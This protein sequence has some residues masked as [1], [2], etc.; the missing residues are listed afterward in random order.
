MKILFVPSD[1]NS[2]SGAFRSM[3]KLN[4][5]LN[6]EHGIE[7]LV[8]LPNKTGD[9]VKLLEKYGVKYCFIES[10]NWIVKSDKELTVDDEYYMNINKHKNLQAIKA[11]VSLIK[12]EKIDIIHINT[13]YSY[14]AAIAG[15]ITK[16]PVVWHL[17]E[18]LEEDQKRR[19]YDREYGY[20]LIGRSEKIITISK[21][22]YTKYENIFPKEKMQVIYNGIDTDDF[23]KP[24]KKI[25]QNKKLT[26][27]C[28]GA[29]NYNKGQDS[30]VHACG[31]LYQKGYQNFELLLAGVCDDRYKGI[32]GGVAKKYGIEDK[33]KIL[34]PRQDV[35][36]LFESADIAFTCSKFEA[37][38]RVTVE[39]MLSGALTIGANSG[40]TV[41]IIEDGKTGL[42]YKQGNTDDL[43]EKIIYA[44][45]HQAE[46][47]KIAKAGREKML[48][49]MTAR[50]NA[51]EIV[52]VY[53]EVIGKPDVPRTVAV[54]VTYNR[55]QMLKDCIKALQ[56]QIYKNFK[57]LI[58]DNASTDG[59]REYVKKFKDKN[60]GYFNTG[61]NL[62]GAGGFNAGMREAYFQ[63][64]K[65]VWIMDDDVIP[66]K[67]ALQELVN[68]SREIK[69]ENVS[70]Y[71]SCVYSLDGQAMN[72]PGIDPKSKNGYPFWFRHLD[73][74]LVNLNAA[75]FVSLLI[76]TNA[77]TKCGLPYSKFFI[78][79]DDSEYTK[80]IYKGY[81]PA[82]LV[83][84]SKVIH[85]RAN[86][87]N[88][89]IFNEDNENRIKM[90]FYM[91]RNTLVYTRA[92]AGQDAFEQKLK[93]FEEDCRILKRSK[94]KFKKQK[95]AIIKAGIKGYYKFDFKEFERRFDV[96][97]EPDPAEN[98]PENNKKIRKEPLIKRMKICYKQNGLKYTLKRIFYGK[99]RSGFRYK[100]GRVITFI[101][102]K[103]YKAIKKEEK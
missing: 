45:E 86:S 67:M 20:D 39:S 21:A 68:A 22:L 26:F 2:T 70:F 32:I 57:I 43:C 89:T 54:V 63:G 14:V 99:Y 40:G 60:I 17:R 12:K 59:T 50:R 27:V 101:P 83:G 31:K 72:T 78:W 13:T 48:K 80:R 15:H 61:K 65:W 29:V 24:N 69:N 18:F 96:F 37:F 98:L 103:I 35:N 87:K 93:Q 23:Y 73:K 11:F 10:Y 56:K 81:G 66:D 4:E 1:N 49:T 47:R 6:K 9:G 90:Y 52:S 28:A 71:A 51:S 77:I 62:G 38:G 85:A 8:V 95:I 55:L 102:R 30:L 94:D 7:T 46:A 25:F 74:G 44:I 91:I 76:N 75:T 97:Y 33:V 92:N 82:Y 42:L 34:G 79:G 36:E 64:A 84:K 41:E 5:I 19:I 58:V 100:F 3:S 16:T 53:N 88:L